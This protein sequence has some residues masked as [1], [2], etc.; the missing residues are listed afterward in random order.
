MTN[1]EF[2]LAVY[3]ELQ[4]NYG[5]TASFRADPNEAG[6][7]AWGG[8]P[9]AH[10]VLS[11]QLL[12]T[13]PYENNFF[14]VSTLRS[15]GLPKRSKDNFERLAV[16]LADD[17]DPV[18]CAYYSYAFETSPG[19]Y[20][21]GLILDPA[22]PDT[23]D[24][25]L[26][27]RVLQGLRSEGIVN[28]DASGNNPVRYARL[29]VGTNTKKNLDVPFAGRVE[30]ADLS[31]VY[32][33]AEA[34]KA[35]GLD[36]DTMRQKEA[37]A[38]PERLKTAPGERVNNYEALL[39]QDPGTRDYHD[40]LLRI[41]SGLI[42]SGAH[43]GAVVNHLREIGEAIE[44]PPG[45]EHD[46]W[47]ARFGAEL[48]RMVGSAEKFAPAPEMPVNEEAGNCLE[49][50][51][52]LRARSRD[53]RWTVDDLIPADS[54]G[55]IFGASGTFKSFLAIDAAMHVA[56]G[57]DWCLRKT[58]QGPVVY[59][60][61]EGGLGLI[62]RIEAWHQLNGLT[63]LVDNFEVCSIPL[64]LTAKDQIAR[65]KR[66]ISEMP[67]PPSLVVIDTLAASFSGDENS[68]SDMS[69][70][71][72][73]INA[74]IRAE[75]GCTVIVVHHTGHNATERPRGSS[76]ILANLDFVLGVFRDDPAEM[77]AKMTVAKQKDGEKAGDMFFS[78]TRL[79]LGQ[80]EEGKEISSLV[81]EYKD[82]GAAL[83]DHVSRG[84]YADLVMMLLRDN[85]RMTQAEIVE[86]CLDE[87]RGIR[88]TALKGVTR[89]ISSL[90]QGGHVRS[91]APGVWAAT[92][93]DQ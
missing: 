78:L 11:G 43:P 13:R 53:I 32:T 46:R 6:P 87:A 61:A 88:A 83:R 45:A 21:V 10:N 68:A 42:A 4:G 26:I 44:P 40:S 49:K 65:L 64:L 70:Y 27:D 2:L 55:M 67:V 7:Q 54:M 28:A 84:R 62:K 57:S 12:D 3:G 31:T 63:D 76:A 69:A 85:P 25:N 38:P 18:D 23:R 24:R 36:L 9:W 52:V 51:A 86:G 14:C 29:P 41:S 30:H 81:A 48:I 20:Q 8:T 19:N 37:L 90:R 71:L 93:R 59:V 35:F 74:E 66:S 77:N 73:S 92:S 91:L 5:W 79:V 75:F 60:A 56:T 50:L 17:V 15:A 22:D 1:S 80:T 72:R 33:L 39:R 82:T 34:V 47:A 58:K 89:A 16:L